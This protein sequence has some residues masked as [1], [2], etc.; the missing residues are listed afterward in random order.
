MKLIILKL[1]VWPKDTNKSPRVLEFKPSSINLITG[2]SKSGKSAILEI[3][4][5]CLAS[6]GCAIPKF[7]PIRRSSS[8]Y[9]VLIET[10][11][12]KKLIARRD[13]DNQDSTDDYYLAE[14]PNVKI[15]DTITKNTNRDVIKGMLARLAEL[16]QGDSDFAETGSGYKGR[17]SFGDMK[18]FVFQPQTIV[19]NKDTM[20]FKTDK[21]EHARKLKEVFPLVLGVVDADMLVKQHRLREVRK[22]LEFR[23]RKL[24][25]L[26]MALRDFTGEVRG[27]YIA[28]IELGLITG[29]IKSINDVDVAVLVMRLKDLLTDWYE[30]RLDYK[31]EDFSISSERF[32]FLKS[33]ES[34]LA[35]QLTGLKVRLT[36]LRE[37]S[38]ARSTSESNLSRERDR[39]SSTS[40]LIEKLNNPNLCPICGNHPAAPSIEYKNLLEANRRVE[41]LWDGIH[42]IPPMLDA[43]EVQIRKEIGVVSEELRQI[44]FEMETLNKETDKTKLVKQQRAIFIGRLEEYLNFQESLDDGSKLVEEIEELENEEQEL[45]KLVDS[46]VLI[47]R[48][49]A[50]LFLISRLAQKYGDILQLETGDDLIQLDTSKLSIKV[51]SQN[52]QSAWIWEIGSG[53]NWLGYHVSTLSALHEF[54]VNKSLPYV[55]SLLV[56]DQPSQ[57][58]FPDDEDEESELEEFHAVRRAF[59]ALSLAIDR[60]KG[61]LQ[62]IVSDHAGSKVVLGVSNVNIVE[63]WRKGRKLIPWHWDE[64]LLNSLV[65]NKADFALEDL[66]DDII[67]PQVLRNSSLTDAVTDIDLIIDSAIFTEKGIKFELRIV[68]TVNNKTPQSISGIIDS[69]LNVFIGDQN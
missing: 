58:H 13:P 31:L 67:K 69:E 27:R 64:E 66:M 54:F 6:S 26:K 29:D 4:D 47:Q 62:V 17:P 14:G 68:S 25:S 10:S 53:A 24:E 44:Q 32:S 46:S 33:Q 48:K 20:F 55:P 21:E 49:E 12:G 43:E 59:E 11:E 3:I 40:W 19:A 63:R 15:Q 37:L 65:G 8:W 41:S 38:M 60:S 50:A 23:R 51:V 5:Y 30:N 39:L 42:V 35:T 56:L 34:L 22:M 1:I 61:T 18:A 28:A 9:G 57:T 2:A 52:G 7:G 36:Q 45:L 16:P